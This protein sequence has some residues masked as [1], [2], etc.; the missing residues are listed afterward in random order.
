MPTLPRLSG[1]A[2]V[3]AFVRGGWQL[4]RQKGSHIILVKDGS[5]ATLSVPDHR[6]VAPGT[7]RSL[8][9]ASGLTVDEFLALTKR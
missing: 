7:L 5:W 2:V 1:R 3:K 6:E 8:I 4:A 9:R